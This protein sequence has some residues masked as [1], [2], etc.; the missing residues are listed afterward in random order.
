M[1]PPASRGAKSMPE[2]C[3]IMG[4]PYSSKVVYTG[5]LHRENGVFAVF[6]CACCSVLVCLCAFVLKTKPID[7]SKSVLCF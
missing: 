3:V 4:C 1:D 2:L 5:S 7:L 6:I